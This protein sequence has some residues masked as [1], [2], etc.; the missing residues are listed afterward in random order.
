MKTEEIKLTPR[1]YALRRFLW[2]NR[3]EWKSSKEIFD[4]VQGYEKRETAYKQINKDVHDI[5]KSG[6][7]DKIII[8]DRVY[9]YKLAT[10]AEFEH[11][12]KKA[13]A[14]SINKLVYVYGVIADSRWD[15]QMII[16]GLEGYQ[17]EAYEKY[18]R[19]EK[20]RQKQCK[21]KDSNCR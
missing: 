21:R 4:N 13:Y 16:P 14:E 2:N 9:G 19:E 18:V 10:K 3:T 15:G 6:K 11:W 8:T 17:R 12:A 1:H 5:N 7:F 20:E